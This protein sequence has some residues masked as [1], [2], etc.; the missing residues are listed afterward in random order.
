VTET[1]SPSTSNDFGEA[2]GNLIIG[3]HGLFIGNIGT[4]SCQL[5]CLIVEGG[6]VIGNVSVEELVLLKSSKITGKITCRHCAIGPDA[7]ILSGLESVNINPLAPDLIDEDDN[8]TTIDEAT[9]ATNG[10]AS[11]LSPPKELRQ[12]NFSKDQKVRG[13]AY[14]DDDY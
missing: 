9:P 14:E 5:K 8:I 1:A 13:R 6:E 4:A 2:E 12:K 3:E 11:W 7:T 10:K